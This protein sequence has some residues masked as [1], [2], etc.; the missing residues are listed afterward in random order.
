LENQRRLSQA[1]SRVGASMPDV[2]SVSGIAGNRLSIE[3]KLH[4]VEEA[5]NAKQA[6]L[7][8][9][10]AQVVAEKSPWYKSSLPKSIIDQPLTA[11]TK[12]E[13]EYLQKQISY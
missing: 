2:S 8:K 6:E 7:G 1:F 3:E 11:S 12:L 5:L 4:L 9:A 10:R 13:F